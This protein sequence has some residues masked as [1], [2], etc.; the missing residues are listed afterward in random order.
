MRSTEV[1]SMK[2]IRIAVIGGTGRIGS[3]LIDGWLRSGL[4]LPDGVTGTGRHEGSLARLRDRGVAATTDNAAAAEGARILVIAVH[5]DETAEVMAQ[6]RPALR[7][8]HLLISTVTGVRTRALEEM[9]GRAIA[10]VRANP[11]IAVLAAQSA[12]VLCRGRHTGE[13]D[14]ALARRLFAAVGLVE[15]LDERHM[16]A[17]TGL[18]GCGPAFVF[19]IIEAMAEGG[20]KMNL[21]RDVSRRIAAQVVKG[22]AELILTT[23]R[24]PAEFKDEVTTP[25]GCTIDGIAKLQERGISIALIDAVETSTRKAGMLWGED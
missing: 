18:G 14:L 3:A 12:T 16:N 6:I 4:V 2:G 11:N 25:G 23:G 15:V 5:P 17:S 22:A 13:E 1:K 20:V 7:D 8:D 19:K 24:H 9:A 10:V 21:P